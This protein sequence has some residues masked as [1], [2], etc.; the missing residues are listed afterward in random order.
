MFFLCWFVVWGLRVV[1]VVFLVGLCV[2]VIWCGGSVR[3]GGIVEW[4]C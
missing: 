4:L 1:V 2:V 3:D